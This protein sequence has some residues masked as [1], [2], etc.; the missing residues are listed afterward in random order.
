M[1]NE[2]KLHR[3]HHI[4]CDDIADNA[5]SLLICASQ[6]FQ[7]PPETGA[8]ADTCNHLKILL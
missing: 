1:I 3:W 4:Y 7:N 5:E 6:D 2:D 8:T